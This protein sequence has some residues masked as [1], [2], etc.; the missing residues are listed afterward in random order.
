MGVY[1]CVCVYIYI[2]ICVCVCLC[3]CVGVNFILAILILGVSS[4]PPK[5]L[6]TNILLFFS[7]VGH[8]EQKQCQD[9]SA[10]IDDTDIKFIKI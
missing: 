7:K 4:Y 8:I 9:Q 1:T 6:I 10:V 3:V 5:D 2:Y